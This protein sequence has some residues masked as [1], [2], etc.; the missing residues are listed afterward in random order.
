MSDEQKGPSINDMNQMTV[1]EFIRDGYLQEV[2]RL[3]FHPLGLALS[4]RL[5]GN[6]HIDGEEEFWKKNAELTEFSVSILDSRDD[7]EGWIFS[8]LTESDIERAEKIA[9]E[10]LAKSAHREWRFGSIKMTGGVQ[11][12]CQGTL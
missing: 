9:R 10:R 11:Q 12:L 1:G 5:D 2:N 4:V 6:I 3:F 7:P 8:E